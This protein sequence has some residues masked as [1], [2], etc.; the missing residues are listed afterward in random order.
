MR[1]V[2]F[3]KFNER[4]LAQNHLFKYSNTVVMS[5]LK[6]MG[7][8]LVTIILALS[9]KRIGL[10]LFLTKFGKS[11]IQRRESKG[12]SMDPCGMP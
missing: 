7:L 4:L 2:S 5:L 8:E 3:P 1:W 11:F 10:D 6:S 12:P 9:A